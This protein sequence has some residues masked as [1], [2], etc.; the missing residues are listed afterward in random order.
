MTPQETAELEVCN[1]VRLVGRVPA[2][3]EERELPSGDVLCTFRVAV[4]RDGAHGG[5]HGSGRQRVD[6][7]E[8]VTF[9]GRVRRSALSWSVGD[10]VEVSGSLRR[11]FFRT[12]GG[13]GSRVEVEVSSARRLR[14][15]GA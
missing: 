7:L 12:A 2:P 1:E 3:A 11:R 8:C 4:T 9:N 15:P 6:S 14:R 13:T 5:A 10:T